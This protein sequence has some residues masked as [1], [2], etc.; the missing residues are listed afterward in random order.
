M[1]LERILD[2][3][4]N[5]TRREILHLLSE[6]PCYVTELSQELEIGHKAIIEHLEG[7]QRAGIIEAKFKKIEK[8]RPRKYFTITQDLILEIRI[9]QDQFDIERLVP[10]IDEDILSSIPKLRNITLR[11]EDISR[12][13]GAQRIRE[14]EVA[15]DELEA[16]LKNIN[17]AKK[18]VEYLLGEI[19]NRLREESEAVGVF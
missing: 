5:E 15:Y 3:L 16:E 18:V 14:L 6:K 9:G 11:L 4:G 13:T 19:R 7:M 10:E 17:E 1:R 12:L 2:M 8:G